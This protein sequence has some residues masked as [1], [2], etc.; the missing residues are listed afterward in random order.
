MVYDAVVWI[1]RGITGWPQGG[2]EPLSYPPE[3]AAE[4]FINAMVHASTRDL[5]TIQ[6]V[7]FDVDRTPAFIRALD[8]ARR[9]QK[10]PPCIRNLRVVDLSQ[11]LGPELRYIL[12]DHLNA[13]GHAV[14]ADALIAALGGK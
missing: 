2:F 10:H 1:K 3:A 7:V 13:S 8:T 12:D 11:K 6:I 9:D 5:G 14:I 4:R